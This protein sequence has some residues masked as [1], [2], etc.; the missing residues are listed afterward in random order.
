METKSIEL[1]QSDVDIDGGTFEGL[2]STWTLDRGGDIIHR[3]AFKRSIK[4][5]MPKGQIK[6]LWQ[7]SEPIGMPIELR[8]TDDGLHVKAKVSDTQLGRDA[9]T[10]MRDGVIDRMSIGFM[11]PKG[12]SEEDDSGIRHIKEL[13]LMEISVVSFP[14]NEAAIITSVKQM[15]EALTHGADIES[16]DDL[17]RSIKRLQELIESRA[18]PEQPIDTK[19]IISII[20][21]FRDKIEAAK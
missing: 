6:I 15:Q 7:H 3:G 11:I 19:G 13:E 20:D 18:S 12:G 4:E 9:M 10:L 5:R 14:M 1:K 21:N 2:A 16:P 8:E 17:L